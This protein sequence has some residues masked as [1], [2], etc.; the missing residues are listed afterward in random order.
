MRIHETDVCLFLLIVIS[1]LEN[2]SSQFR[3]AQ[4]K[5]AYQRHITSPNT[6]FIASPW[7]NARVKLSQLIK[8]D[9]AD[10]QEMYP[11]QFL[12]DES[13][14]LGTDS[15]RFLDYSRLSSL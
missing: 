6:L 12:A 5:G 2:D 11:L 14:Q 15:K 7:K 10:K 13:K 8:K 9:M 4:E 1:F 3:T